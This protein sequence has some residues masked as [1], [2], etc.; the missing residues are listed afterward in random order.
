MEREAYPL[1][2]RSAH[3]AGEDVVGW[4]ESMLKALVGRVSTRKEAPGR[5]GQVPRLSAAATDR[6]EDASPDPRAR[7][8]GLGALSL[9]TKGIIVFLAFAV[10]AT[11]FGIFL[12]YQKHI[13]L[14][15]FDELRAIAQT[16]DMVVRFEAAIF[17]RW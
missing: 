11:G 8:R 7:P 5:P 14:N 13:L 1:F 9:R 3:A 2:L 12:L 4:A 15:Q 10:Y 16:G 6:G 17:S